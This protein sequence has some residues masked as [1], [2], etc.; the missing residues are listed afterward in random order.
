MILEI[1]VLALASTVRPTSLA[2]V[3]ALLSHGSRRLLWVYVIAGLAFSISF[4][5]IVVGVFHGIHLDAG[6]DRTKGIA[7]IVGGTV[8][9]IFA[10]GVATGRVWGRE[11]QDAPRVNSRWTTQLEQRLSVRTAAI[12][13]PLTHVPGIFYLVALN[14]IVAH[15]PLLPGGVVAVLIFDVI[16]FALPILA[17]AFS[18]VR[19][20]AA[21][22]MIGAVQQWSRRN[23]RSILLLTSTSIGAAL[24]IRG[25]LTL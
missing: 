24:L 5:V 9:L 2:A 16:W 21:M 22:E 7:D 15:N 18:V 20:G 10:A 1:I 25:L 4:G 6:S 12:A 3:Y 13:G 23:A 19:P 14:L 11:G 17:L 8:A